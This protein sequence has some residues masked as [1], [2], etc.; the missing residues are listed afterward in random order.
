MIKAIFLK[1]LVD[2]HYMDHFLATNFFYLAM[3]SNSSMYFSGT[4]TAVCM[5]ISQQIYKSDLKL[6]SSDLIS[7]LSIRNRDFEKYKQNKIYML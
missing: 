5:F 7:V 6:F 1:T 2:T 4:Y 3:H